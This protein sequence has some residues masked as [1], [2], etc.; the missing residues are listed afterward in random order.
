VAV[1]L[2]GAP[3]VV[4]LAWTG[5]LEVEAPTTDLTPGQA[6]Q[7]TRVLDFEALDGA[8][9]IAV[10]GPSGSTATLRLHGERPASADSGTLR[11]G[12]GVTELVVT[13]PASGARFSRTE[14]RLGRP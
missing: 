9:R 14:I 13:F 6:D 12:P 7:G 4:E 3:R 5:G 8:F 2:S 11:G 10:E 1:A